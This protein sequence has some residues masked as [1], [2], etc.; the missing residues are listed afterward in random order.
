MVPHFDWS[1]EY[2]LDLARLCAA[3][4]RYGA[5]RAIV[6]GSY[7]RGDFDELSDVDLVVIK[8]TASPYFQRASELAALLPFGRVDAFV[9][10]PEEFEKM[11][12][13]GNALA[14]IVETE[15]VILYERAQGAT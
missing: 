1:Q 12:A 13:R 3:L 4:E 2:P 5:E 14:E 8:Q 10:T 6:F 11:K 7:A 15:G 9:F